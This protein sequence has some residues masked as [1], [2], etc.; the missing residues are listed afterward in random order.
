MKPKRVTIRGRTW[1]LRW[2]TPTLRRQALAGYCLGD[3]K[4]EIHVDARTDDSL[5]TL[6]HETLHASCPYLEEDEVRQI[7]AD[8]TAVLAAIG[9]SMKLAVSPRNES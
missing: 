9:V 1:T 2:N 3:P 7:E 8:I 6:I 4:R 5:G